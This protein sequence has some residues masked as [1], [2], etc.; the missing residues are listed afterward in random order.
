MRYPVHWVAHSASPYNAHLFRALAADPTI[1]LTVHYMH[2]PP[3]DHPWRGRMTVGYPSHQCTRVA[4][5]CW[6]LVHLA[7]QD[8]QS[9][10][11]TGNWSEPTILLS[12]SLLAARR[13]PFVMWTGT[14][15]MAKRRNPV[16]AHLRLAWLQRM[17]AGAAR[18]MG[19]GVPALMNLARMGCPSDK[20]VNFPLFVPLNGLGPPRESA[21]ES[22]DPR[23]LRLI[24][25]GRV[26]HQIKG[27]DIAVRALAEARELS[28]RDTFEYRI[29]GSGRD[30][31][32]LRRQAHQ[33]GLDDRVNFLGWLEPERVYDLYRDS[34]ILL[35]PSRVD[36]FGAA[37]LEAMAAGLVVLGSEATAA[38]RDRIRHGE[39]GFVHPTGNVDELARQIGHLLK[40]P[41]IIPEIGH[42]ARRTAEEWPV[43]RGVHIIKSILAD[44]HVRR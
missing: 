28:G 29:A 1:E 38:V 42:Q 40:H 44:I 23:T 8:S 32:A 20:L 36:A 16:K 15:D 27:H 6:D 3:A 14:P 5:I 35:H 37:V 10:V 24:S 21:R 19:T 39:N 12:L 13:R 25:V 31:E 17:F 43:E 7:A 11:V 30:L 41:G 18:V 34:D 33:L 9:L 26:I 2:G 22:A 4:G